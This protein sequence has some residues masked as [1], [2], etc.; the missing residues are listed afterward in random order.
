MQSKMK[1]DARYMVR[2][3][4][5]ASLLCSASAF[6][7]QAAVDLEAQA[8]E[9]W[10]ES[11]THIAPPA[12]GCFH[13]TYPSVLWEKVTCNTAT[14]RQHPVL[15]RDFT[16]RPQTTGNGNDYAIQASGLISKTVGTFPSVSGVT[17]EQGVGVSSFGG[18]GILGPNEYTLQINSNA[19]SSTAACKNHSGCVVWEQFVYSPDYSTQGEAAVFMQ[20]WLIGY[21]GSSCPSGWGSDGGG[22]CYK[23]SAAV[24]APDV[25]ITQLA[26]LKLSGSATAGGNDTAVFTNGTQAYT[27]SGKDSVVYL[28]SVWSESEF[29]VVGNAG[30]SEA[31]FNSGSSVTVKVAV[32]DGTT[33]TPTC[34]SNAGTT[35]ES[36]NLNLGSC[37]TSGGSTPSIQFTESN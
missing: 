20:Y 31:D 33:S 10:R 9:G 24:T 36:N 15:R 4:V 13:A 23:N 28:A 32:T 26:N 2:I 1:F 14:P 5:V 19:D 18:G 12:E 6:A 3:A 34:A 22:D 37:S 17:S 30:G 29:N 8:H 35:G 27:V 21:G 25:P 7:A 11:I 16:G